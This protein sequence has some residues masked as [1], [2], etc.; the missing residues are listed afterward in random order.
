MNPYEITQPLLEPVS[1]ALAKQHVRLEQDEDFDDATLAAYIAAARRWTEGHARRS[2]I[3][4]T[5]GYALDQ[6]PDEKFIVLPYGPV[7]SILSLTY[8][9]E[10]DVEHTVPAGDY[11]LAP[12]TDRLIL[13]QAWPPAA[14]RAAEAIEV[15]YVA[16]Y[17]PAASDVPAE[18][19]QAMLLLVG[20]Y[21]ENRE[22][23]LAAVNVLPTLI[24]N[25]ARALIGPLVRY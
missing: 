21:Y 7:S 12:R 3:N 6:W 1:L 5:M 25:G 13:K 24:A 16:G 4:R 14:L 9:D 19:V 8:T 18:V 20:A 17:G 23:E 2:W 10:D 11:Y 22:D 15:Q